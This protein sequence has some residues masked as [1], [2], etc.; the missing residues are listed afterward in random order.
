MTQT[1]RLDGP[2]KRPETLAIAAALKMAH[3][4]A[5]KPTEADAP[6]LS[7]LPMTRAARAALELSRGKRRA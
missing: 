4:P 2:D 7:T 1:G 3:A 6:P 5:R